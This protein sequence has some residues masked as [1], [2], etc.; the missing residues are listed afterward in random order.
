MKKMAFDGAQMPTEEVTA[1][2]G[3]AADR[4]GT[5]SKKG[6]PLPKAARAAAP[7]APQARAM[8]LRLAGECTGQVPCESVSLR[9]APRQERAI[10]LGHRADIERT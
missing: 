8:L 1:A 9:R 3:A 5:P 10:R 7:A 4:K 2:E 6:T